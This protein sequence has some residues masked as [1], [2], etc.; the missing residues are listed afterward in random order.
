[1][2][3]PSQGGRTGGDRDRDPDGGRC[4]ERGEWLDAPATPT[5]F[6]TSSPTTT[7]V[8]FSPVLTLWLSPSQPG[9]ALFSASS[10]SSPLTPLSIFPMS[11]FFFLHLAQELK[12]YDPTYVAGGATQNTIRVAQWI[13]GVPGATT[14]FGSVGADANASLLRETVEADGVRASYHVSSGSPTGTCACAVVGGE[15][16]LV[17][18]LGAANE[19]AISH[20]QA[21]E[22]WAVLQRAKFVYSA[23]FFLTAS[24]E[25]MLLAAKDCASRGVPYGLNISAPFLVE[26]PPF[27]KAMDDVLPFATHVFG[28]ETEAAAFARAEGWTETDLET[29]ASRIAA[30]PRAD[31]RAEQPRTVVIT[32]GAQSTIV[33]VGDEPV[34]TF[35]VTPIPKD[36]LVDTNGAG[37]A[38]VGGF[39]AKT[40]QGES[41]ENAVLAGHYAAGVI[42]KRSGCSLP[43]EKPQI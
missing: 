18:N 12:Q 11:L 33:A 22:N 26:V 7:Y 34:R 35:T 1:M 36:Q 25:S 19:Y 40:V 17:A 6:P 23:G 4:H 41:L 13:L 37:D 5:S 8:M 9:F 3:Q 2:R 32:Q 24:P 43:K 20:L 29:I 31:G 28:N 14:Y 30:L 27:K 42:V 38:F 15:R 10:S 16:S 39:L 21:P